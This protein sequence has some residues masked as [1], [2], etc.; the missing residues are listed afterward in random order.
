MGGVLRIGIDAHAI[1][2]RKTGNERFI[3]NVARELREICEHELVLFFT[4]EEAARHWPRDRRTEVQ[5]V[6]PAEPLVRVPLALPALARREKLDVML[7]QYSAGPFMPCPVVTVVHDVSFAT[8]P[9]SF[10]R[11]ERFWMPRTIPATMRRAARIVTVSGFSRDEISRVY[12]IPAERIVIAPDGVDPVFAE[13]A[14]LTGPWKP[15][16]FL[17]VGNIEPRKNLRVAIEAFRTMLNEHPDM[18]ERLLIVGEAR[19]EADRVRQD[20]ADLER[21]GRVAFLGWVGDEELNALL[22]NATALVYP[23]VYEGFGLPVVEAMA[24]GTPVLAGDIPVMHEVS[25][26]ACVL[27]PPHE[28]QGW[29]E[30]MHLIATDDAW[31]ND[32]VARGLERSKEFTWRRTAEAVLEALEGAA[33]KASTT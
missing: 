12:G 17:W 29:A 16:F 20:A 18:M 1:G 10:S 3:S 32:I 21:T 31:R 33:A 11:Y 8:Q 5:V 6:R 13:P 27:L 9:E 7:V 28:P 25:A 26:G 15:P 30:A 22:R 23:S 24:S 19:Y 4:E 14:E 2:E